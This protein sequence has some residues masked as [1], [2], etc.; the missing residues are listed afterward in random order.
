M[1]FGLSEV[2]V[3]F[4]LLF[5]TIGGWLDMMRPCGCAK[6]RC[7]VCKQKGCASCLHCGQR[8]YGISKMHFWIDGLA[9]LVLAVLLRC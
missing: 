2:F 7:S 3:V 9:L 8:I 1:E 4:G 6:G 5:L